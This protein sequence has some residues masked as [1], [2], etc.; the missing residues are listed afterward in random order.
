MATLGMA[1]P[2][3][4]DLCTRPPPDRERDDCELLD[5]LVCSPPRWGR[6]ADAEDEDEEEEEKLVAGAT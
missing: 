4:R 2:R 1:T 3:W 6:T 5:E